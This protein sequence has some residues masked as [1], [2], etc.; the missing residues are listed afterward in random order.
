[1]GVYF[2]C[3]L[4]AERFSICCRKTRFRLFEDQSGGMNLIAPSKTSKMVRISVLPRGCNDG[5]VEYSGDP[6]RRCHSHAKRKLVLHASTPRPTWFSKFGLYGCVSKQG[7]P[8]NGG[9]SFVSL[10]NPLPHGIASKNHFPIFSQG[11]CVALS[12]K[13]LLIR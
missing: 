6:I 7:G 8:T 2:G 9:F 11:T 5:A 3:C 4:L 1:M 13:T 12:W 10:F